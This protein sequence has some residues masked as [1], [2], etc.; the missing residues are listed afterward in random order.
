MSLLLSPRVD[1]PVWEPPSD[2]LG[3][4]LPHMVLV[5]GVAL[6]PFSAIPLES[7][8]KAEQIPKEQSKC[9]PRL[10]L[11]EVLLPSRTS[12]WEKNEPLLPPGPGTTLLELPPDLKDHPYW[13]G[14]GTAS[15]GPGFPPS[16]PRMFSGSDGP[17]SDG[18]VG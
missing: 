18:L 1:F 12:I 11:S 5:P 15:R 4:I 2:A 8:S 10:V 14:A 7:L 6:V 13:P 9:W 16:Q 3:F 17:A